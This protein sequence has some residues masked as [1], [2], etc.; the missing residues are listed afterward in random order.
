VLILEQGVELTGCLGHQFVQ[1]N[2]EYETKS[3]EEHISDQPK[4]RTRAR[5]E[6][7]DRARVEMR[8]EEHLGLRTRSQKQGS[9]GSTK[10]S[11]FSRHDRGSRGDGVRDLWQ[12]FR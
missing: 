5:Y 6:N 11:L 4:S 7:G 3:F 9:V 12:I 1:T 8:V 10:Q 2:V